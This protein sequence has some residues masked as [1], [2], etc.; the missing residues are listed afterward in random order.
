MTLA[1]LGL[2]DAIVPLAALAT[3]MVGF[4][5]GLL[6]LFVPRTGD[7]TRP[8][9]SRAILVG[10]LL[11]ASALMWIVLPGAI[12]RPSYATWWAAIQAMM[13]PM[14]APF[15][16]MMS[17]LAHAEERPID[18]AGLIWP[19]LLA[20]AVVL[21]EA[22]MGYAFAAIAGAASL[23]DP[24]VA[25]A[26]SLNSPWF[27]VSMFATMVA[28]VVWVPGLWWKRCSLVG[29]AA[30]GI[31]GPLWL[32]DPVLSASAMAVVM[33]ATVL[34]LALGLS[35]ATRERSTLGRFAF[36]VGGALGLM[37]AAGI[38]SAVGIGG[39]AEGLPIAL[40]AGVVMLLETTYLL[41]GALAAVPDPTPPFRWAA[42]ASTPA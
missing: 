28:L 23:N 40:T 15:F 27:A 29:L 4:Q 2:T 36:A 16:W 31:A 21:N 13:V 34:V 10:Y 35:G 8:R 24:A 18:R 5:L 7:P 17:Q 14:P 30:T 33:T 42:D 1:D 39:A 3:L 19:L 32:V 25:I 11:P 41:R 38:A 22:V 6:Y 37:T 20:G 12:L 26:L 9:L